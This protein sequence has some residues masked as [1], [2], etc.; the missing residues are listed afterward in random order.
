MTAIKGAAI[1]PF[2]TRPNPEISGALIYGPDRGRVR[3]RAK[4]IVTAVLGDDNEGFALCELDPAALS[5]D[6]GLLIDELMAIPFMGGRKIVWLRNPDKKA[7]NI[8]LK[9]I[10]DTRTKDALLL[11]EAA[12]LRPV[13]PLRKAFEKSKHLAAIACFEDDGRSLGEIIDEQLAR[14]GHSIS[15]D[16]RAQLIGQLGSDRSLSRSEIEK[17]CLYAGKPRRIELEDVEAISGDTS[18]LTMDNIADS[19]AGGDKITF[20]RDFRRAISSGIPAAT[21]LTS[22][23]LHISRLHYIHARALDG[24]S[25]QSLLA[26][27]RPPIHFKRR[28]GFIRQLRLWH[29]PGLRKALRILS[30]SEYQSRSSAIN[31]ATVINR[32]LLQITTLAASR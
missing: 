14:F 17:I 30:N 28:D 18:S 20:E 25:P 2:L 32:A 31:P 4:K 16:A 22:V 13:S 24:S 9:V 3:E 1:K 6:P 5:A 7:E 26:Q 27:L 23:T 19:V 10:K 21:I 11:I 8:I 29:E 15:R 12:N